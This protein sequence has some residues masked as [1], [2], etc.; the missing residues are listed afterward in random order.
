MSRDNNTV[1]IRAHLTYVSDKAIQFIPANTKEKYWL[2]KSQI[3]NLEDVL[4][5][6]EDFESY[7]DIEA[8]EWIVQKNNI[9]TVDETGEEGNEVEELN[10]NDDEEITF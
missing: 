5:E 4:I 9:P 8:K 6:G 7:I 3:V 1:W 10:F 2:P